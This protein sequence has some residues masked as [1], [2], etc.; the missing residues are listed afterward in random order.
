MEEK[1]ITIENLYAAGEKFA[2]IMAHFPGGGFAETEGHIRRV[3]SDSVSPA[4]YWVGRCCFLPNT[5]L[6]ARS[7]DAGNFQWRVYP[8]DFGGAS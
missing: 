8:Q 4:N 1:Q 5:L 7:E 3:P 2:L 6:T